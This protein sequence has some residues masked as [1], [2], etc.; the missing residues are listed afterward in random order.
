[1]PEVKKKG[2][3][4]SHRP[5][6]IARGDSVQGMVYSIQILRGV[7]ALLVVLYHYSHYLMPTIPGANIGYVLFGGGYAGVDIFFIISGFIIVL[8]TERKEHANPLDFS[9]RR[10]F[11]VVPLAQFA[12]VIYALILRVPPSP[13]LLWQ[14][15]LFLPRADVDPP[16]FGLPVV[17][18]EWTLSYELIFYAIFAWAL[19][20]THRRRV[21]TA[22]F[23]TL[24]CVVGFQWL[25]GGPISPVPNSV[26]LPAKYNGV[27]SPEVLG[28]LG[29]P[30]M[31]EF[32]FGMLL[33]AAY[34]RTEIWLRSEK[35]LVAR[36]SVGLLLAIV[37]LGS[38]FSRADPG[39][40]LLNKGFGA[41]CLVT[42]MLLMEDF[43][44]RPSAGGLGGRI[45][46]CFLWLGSISYALYLVHLGIS[47]RLLRLLVHLLMAQNVDGLWGFLALMAE[48]LLLAWAVNVFVERYLIRAGKLLIEYKNKLA[49]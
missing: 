46:S 4:S 38:Y 36:W 47:E 2:Y 25:L 9:I 30:I 1:M 14:S 16:K 22:A 31:L 37:F 41:A 3:I 48:S 12:T 39:N 27:L 21:I 20:F 24:A 26:Y 17:N 49:G 42:G 6:R 35:S 19:I 32:V 5:P 29:N 15:L 33:A 18:Q 45:L 13:K 8:S 44:T 28:L 11:R 43:F 23:A 7:A 10:F 40:G 34:L